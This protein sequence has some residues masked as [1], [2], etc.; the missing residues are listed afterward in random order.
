MN[1]TH[2]AISP[3]AGAVN[4]NLR[5][6]LRLEGL[7][8]MVAA[9]S[10]YFILGGNPWLFMLL[11]FAPD[12]SFAAYAI[13]ARVGAAVYNT[14]HSYILPVLLGGAGW[15]LGVDLLWQLALVVAAHAGFDRS[16]GYGLKY[17]SAFNHTHLGA[18]GRR[19]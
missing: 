13:N 15:F 19:A 4:G 6:V 16:L 9:A 5:S 18:I 8:A 17:A 11:F 10:S 2:K 14:V 1:Q 12:I 7:A 3:T